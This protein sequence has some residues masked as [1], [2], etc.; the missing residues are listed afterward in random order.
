MPGASVAA[1]AGE[2]AAAASGGGGG[3]AAR[4]DAQ[5]TARAANG[6][7][8]AKD[9]PADTRGPVAEVDDEGF[10]TVRGSAWRRR[11]ATAAR[12]SGQGEAHDQATTPAGGS[13]ARN[14]GDEGEGGR[15]AGDANEEDTPPSAEDL[16]QA[17]MA[18]VAVV[19]RLRQQGLAAEHPAMLA[20][21]S[22]R[23]S[24]ET[25]WREAKDPAPPAVRLNRVQEKLDRAVA[26]QAESRAAITE[27]ERAHKVRL[28]ELQAKLDEDEERVRLR[29]RQLQEVQDE[30]AQGGTSDRSRARQG[31][32]V[33]KVHTALASTVAPAISA[34]VDQ[35]ES[36]TPA[37][38]ILNGL[39][40]TLSNSQSLLE[41]AMAGAPPVQTFDI[42]EEEGMERCEN[43]GNGPCDGSDSEWSE[44][45]EMRDVWS[46]QGGPR[47]DRGATQDGE[48]AGARDSAQTTGGGGWWQTSRADWEDG[49]RWQECGHGKW[50]KA[51]A[52]WAD[53]WE[54]EGAGVDG[55]T[56]QPAAARRRLGPAPQGVPNCTGH[57]A[58]GG[59]DPA[60]DDTQRRQPH[61]DRVQLIIAAA[62]EAGVQPLTASGED[63]QLLS[64]EQLDAWAAENLPTGR[65][66]N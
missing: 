46:E 13:G 51:R 28:A 16:R 18:E 1:R 35:L 48:W 3:T 55:E 41:E 29:R 2:A 27:L 19:K 43:G 38:S 10:Q 37:W 23:D 39:L 64:P 11:M 30:I 4:A 50:A 33:Q 36:S 59:R 6:K 53:A 25:R 58:D 42:G 24:A 17:W 34:L 22:A 32:A 49:V 66:H 12:A 63:L 44:S 57:D 47:T 52:S 5:P 60:S 45:H 40:G 15:D 21:C 8:G 54:S 61:A 26:A 20:A 31:V 56:D 62:I 7:Q 9:G 65:L 14:D